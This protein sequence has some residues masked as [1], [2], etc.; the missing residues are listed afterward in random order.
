MNIEILNSLILILKIIGLSWFITHFDPIMWL[1]D[2]ARININHKRTFIHLIFNV[3]TV[4]LTCLKCCSFWLGLTI[5]GSIWIAL[6]ASYLSFLYDKIVG[7]WES[8]INIPQNAEE[9]V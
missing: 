7:P 9:E 3:I 4:L 8:I 5:S 1:I 6:A 2:S